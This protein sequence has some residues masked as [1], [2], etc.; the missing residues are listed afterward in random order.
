M[1]QAS[2]P[3]DLHH[4]E[5]RKLI[6][7]ATGAMLGLVMAGTGL[8]TAQGTR[9]AGVPP[10]DVATVNQIPILMSDYAAALQASE[11][12]G[13]DK[14]TPQQKRKILDQMIREELYVQR[15]LELGLPADVTEVRQAMVSAVEGQQAVDAAATQPDE[16]TLRD[17]YIRHIDKYA[18]EGMLTISDVLAPDMARAQAAVAALRAGEPPV[19]VKPSGKMDQGAEFYFA[20]RIHLGKTLFENAKALKSGQVSNPIAQ[21]DG[22]HVLIVKNNT[23]PTI[24]PFEQARDRVLGDYRKDKIR[25]MQA[26]ADIFL[27]K[28]ADVQIAPGFQ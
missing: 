11:G 23:A 20:A 14:A 15:G 25:R 18:G 4:S 3:G 28:R 2:Q 21:A 19:G 13:L 26:G 16:A 24:T 8:F 10:E 6:F 7:C 1:T 5:K 12:V 9:T 17:F 27:R 22:V